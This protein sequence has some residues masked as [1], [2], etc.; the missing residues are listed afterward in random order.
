MW[1]LVGISHDGG[2]NRLCKSSHRHYC[3]QWF[4][5]RLKTT[6][7]GSGLSRCVV[8]LARPNVG[9]VVVVVVHEGRFIAVVVFYFFLLLPLTATLGGGGGGAL[10]S[11]LLLLVVIVVVVVVD[12]FVVLYVLG[13]V[14]FGRGRVVL[15]S[16]FGLNW[17]SAMLCSTVVCSSN[18]WGEYTYTTACVY[19]CIG[20]R[21]K[22][23]W[24]HCSRIAPQRP[25]FA[26]HP[27]WS[28]EGCARLL[29]LLSHT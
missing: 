23:F 22:R 19:V 1:V 27:G 2:H 29:L 9:V 13:P 8:G 4:A 26:I 14:G 5:N 16:L 11:C 3:I 7:N 10:L 6:N 18:G 21:K 28:I 15:C 24:K 17:S 20:G 25:A 12:V